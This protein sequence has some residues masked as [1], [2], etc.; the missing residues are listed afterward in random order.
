M[1]SI[2]RTLVDKAD[3]ICKILLAVEKPPQRCFT[4]GRADRPLHWS[5][6]I[7]AGKHATRWDLENLEWMCDPCNSRHEHF[8]EYYTHI[9][10][11]WYGKTQYD[12]LVK[13]SWG[14]EGKP[15]GIKE[16]REL[17]ANMEGGTDAHNA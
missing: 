9:Y 3:R 4:C 14:R 16:L 13:R 10:L 8:P 5:H 7:T 12:T 11:D 6:L 1:K 17:I 15:F 2:R